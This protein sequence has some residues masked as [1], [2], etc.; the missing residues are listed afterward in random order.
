MLFLHLSLA[1]PSHA[2]AGV[3]QK[4]EEATCAGPSLLRDQRPLQ[5]LCQTPLV[6]SSLVWSV[7]TTIHTSLSLLYSFVMYTYLYHICILYTSLYIIN[8]YMIYYI[9]REW[10]RHHMIYLYRRLHNATACHR[11]TPQ[12]FVDV[13]YLPGEVLAVY[14]VVKISQS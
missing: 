3:A 5:M 8:F 12:K 9:E 14:L 4:L 13:A 6:W 7:I 11:R 2:C 10:E 1:V